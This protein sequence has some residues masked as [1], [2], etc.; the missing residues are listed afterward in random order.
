MGVDPPRCER[1]TQIAKDELWAVG[2]LTPWIL[3]VEVLIF[4]ISM[5]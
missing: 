3:M 5:A 2:A 4:E 1:P